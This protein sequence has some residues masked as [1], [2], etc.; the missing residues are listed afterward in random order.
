M[1]LLRILLGLAM[2]YCLLSTL[3]CSLTKKTQTTKAESTLTDQKQA[4][5]QR[6]LLSKDQKE[7][8]LLTYYPDGTVHQFQQI[9]EEIEKQQKD[10][11]KSKEETDLNTQVVSK[12]SV[13]VP[14]WWILISI[15]LI[16][17]CWLVYQKMKRAVF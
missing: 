16:V 1:R 7:T 3:S 11:L 2:I 8:R 4:E 5:F 13:P 14:Q 15:G 17:V 6:T 9:V 12:T 10:L